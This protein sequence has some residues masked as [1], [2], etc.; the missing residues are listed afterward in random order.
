M[1]DVIIVG[2]GPA[3]LTAAIYARRSALSALVLEREDWGGAIVNAAQVDNYP[4]AF[5]ESG[6][7][8]AESFRAQAEALGAEM[9]EGSAV[10]LSKINGGFL[11]TLEDGSAV[12]GKTV[13]LAMGTQRTTLD[14]PGEDLPGVSYCATCDG[15]FF[16]GRTVCVVGGGDGAVDAARLLARLATKVCLIH[17]RE[18]FRAA[19]SSLRQLE[20]CPNV[21][22]I[23]NAAV[24]EIAGSDRVSTVILE[25]VHSRVH[26]ELPVDGVFVSI[27]SQP[28]TSWLPKAIGRDA[29]GYLVASEDGATSLP[30]VF[31]AGDLRTKAL[32][33]VVTAAAD[34][35]ACIRS[36]EAYLGQP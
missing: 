5:Q 8:L 29:A 33:Q 18:T 28:N 3:G 36:V 35:A 25:D 15:T 7:D 31:A 17:R 6:F 20:D 30:G 24:R 11:L 9:R 23:P 34:G 22:I 10:Q 21:E 16:R 26:R 14:V 27:G 4:G 1:Y 19:Q 13:V 2:G 12:Q 32:R